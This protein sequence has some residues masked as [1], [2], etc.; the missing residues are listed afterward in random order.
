M[1][2]IERSAPGPAQTASKRRVTPEEALRRDL[3]LLLDTWRGYA[4]Y[5]ALAERRVSPGKEQQ[6]A[7]AQR[8]ALDTCV[9]D[10]VAVLAGRK[11][12]ERPCRI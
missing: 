5:Y 10:L 6:A 7:I 9:E 11:P 2:R 4:R 3:G 1:N 12:V 8:V